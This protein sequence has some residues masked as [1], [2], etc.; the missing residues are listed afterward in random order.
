MFLLADQPPSTWARV[1]EATHVLVDITI[2]LGGLAAIVK[3]QL[4]HLL[5]HRWHSSVD[6]MHHV[7][8]DGS[9]VFNADYRVTNTGQRP[10]YVREVKL[11]L[12][13]ARADGALLLPDESAHPIA[14]RHLSADDLRTRGN[15]RI[16]PGERTIFPRR[17]HLDELPDYVFI[18]CAFNPDSRRPGTI[19][20]GFYCRHPVA[21]ETRVSRPVGSG[22]A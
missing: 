21:R 10:I 2:L 11:R 3:F 8:P 17:C 1:G 6:C 18:S 5:T 16:E 22:A 20:R 12:L 9:I 4:F 19:F 14:S 7:L 13:P 15:F